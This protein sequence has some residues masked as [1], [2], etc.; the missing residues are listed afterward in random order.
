MLIVIKC[1]C[2]KEWFSSSQIKHLI[3][4]WQ[5]FPVAATTETLDC[6]I[7]MKEIFRHADISRAEFV[8][9][10]TW[11]HLNRIHLCHSAEGSL[12]FWGLKNK[13]EQGY[14]KLGLDVADVILFNSGF[15]EQLWI[16]RHQFQSP[17]LNKQCPSVESIIAFNIMHNIM[18]FDRNTVKTGK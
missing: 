5:G 4:K 10:W 9:E 3:K 6:F 8:A 11:Y 14:L 7:K 16:I 18:W 1:H 2:V 17:I 15:I 12:T 13:T